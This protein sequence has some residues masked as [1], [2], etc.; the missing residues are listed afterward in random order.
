M[1]LVFLQFVS[2]LIKAMLLFL[3]ASGLSLIFGVSRVINL[4]HASFY[5]LGA[6]LFLSVMELIPNRTLGYGLA[7]VVVPVAIALLAGALEIS[8]LRRAYR[9]GILS[10]VIVTF[11]LIFLIEGSTRIIWSDKQIMIP[12]PE[13][14]RGALSL[15][16]FPISLY[17]LPIV[18]VAPLVGLGIWFVFYRTR[19]GMVVRAATMDREMLG[20]LGINVPRVFTVTFVLAAWLAGLGGVLAAP[21]TGVTPTMDSTIIIEAFAVVV[22]GGLGSIAGSFIAALLIGELLAF[23]LLVFP[24]LSLALVFIVMAVVLASRPWGLM[25]RPLPD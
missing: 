5:M 8:L 3:V 25:G 18:I 10:V 9:G 4:A 24:A 14:L 2:G 15:A 16:G 17:Y 1:E 23:G 12:T 20:A 13:W 21:T 11:G 6:Y 7:L 22:I 19:W